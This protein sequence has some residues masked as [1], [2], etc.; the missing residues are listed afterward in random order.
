RGW[1]A[2]WAWRALTSGS[3]ATASKLT[4]PLSP[5]PILPV[6]P[7]LPIM[8]QVVAG[9]ECGVGLEGFDEW[10]QGDSI[11][12]FEVVQKARSLE[13]ASKEVTKAVAEKTESMGITV[14]S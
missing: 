4:F 13:D 2:G 7:I 14:N 12:A 1:S 10:Q 9:L 5:L 6:I 11:E 8:K 3:R